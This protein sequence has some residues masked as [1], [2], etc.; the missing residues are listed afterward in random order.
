MRIL[1]VS[2]SLRADS[3]NTRLLAVASRL[4]MTRLDSVGAQPC[5]SAVTASPMIAVGLLMFCPATFICV[6]L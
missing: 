2:G 6:V 4:L 5:E 3:H 1:G